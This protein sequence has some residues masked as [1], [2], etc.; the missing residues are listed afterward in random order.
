LK[1]LAYSR[2]KPVKKAAKKRP[3]KTP[4]NSEDCLQLHTAQWLSKELPNLLAF[5]VANER[6]GPV[7]MHVKLKRKGVL[8]GVADWLIFPQNGRKAAIELKDDEGE[9]EEDQERFQTRWEASGGLYFV[10]RTLE[11][12]Q[13]VVLGVALFG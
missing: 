5:H 1:N 7:Q 4:E 2:K 6:K 9:Q 11:E 12:F 3:R 13:G 8:A 10:C